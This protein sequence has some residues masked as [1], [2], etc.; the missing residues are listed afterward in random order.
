M[1][2]VATSRYTVADLATI[3]AVACPCGW[4]RRAFLDVPEGRASLHRVDISVDAK[5]HFHKR[6]TE[7]YYVLEC[8]LGAA[9]ELD[10]ERV[11]VHAGMS[12]YI[13]P[14][15]RHRAV[16]KMKVLVVAM[17]QFDPADEWATDDTPADNAV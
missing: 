10:G 8:E 7:I 4:S 12:V 3:P 1:S 9:M 14:F 13:P 17:P 11:P 2:T 16:G 15:T 5:T 6:L